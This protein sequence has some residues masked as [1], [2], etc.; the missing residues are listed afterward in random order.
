MVNF[1]L[2]TV[3]Q[4]LGINIEGITFHDALDD[5]KVTR[6]I[7]YLLDSKLEIHN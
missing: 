6:D 5:V 4:T 2:A 3:A 1:K 7:Y